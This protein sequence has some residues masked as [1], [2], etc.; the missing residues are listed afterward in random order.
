MPLAGRSWFTPP[1]G[2]ADVRM[3]HSNVQLL[4]K[5]RPGTETKGGLGH[6]DDAHSLQRVVRTCRR[7]LEPMGQKRQEATA[8]T[9]GWGGSVLM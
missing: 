2:A 7:L 9:S 8:A 4:P 1:D 3:C 6:T 5:P